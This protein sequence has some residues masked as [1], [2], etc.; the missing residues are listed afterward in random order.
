M[1]TPPPIGSYFDIILYS[2]GLESARQQWEVEK[3]EEYAKLQQGSQDLATAKQK[4]MSDIQKK[5]KALD[6][7]QAKLRNEIEIANKD[8]EQLLLD[9]QSVMKASSELEIAEAREAKKRQV[10]EERLT[11]EKDQLKQGIYMPFPVVD[12]YTHINIC[13]LHCFEHTSLVD[14]ILELMD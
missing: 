9:K 11:K 5:V 2:T 4:A 12:T 1:L 8:K 6:E 7:Q 3:K 13:F 14:Y 10:E